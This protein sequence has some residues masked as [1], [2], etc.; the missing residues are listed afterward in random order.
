VL[1]STTHGA[2]TTGLAAMLA[3]IEAF[4]AKN[5]IEGNWLRGEDLKSRLGKIIEKHHLTSFLKI[6]GYPCLFTLAC[7]NPRGEIDDFYRTLM[8]QEMITRGVLFQG[9]FYPTWSH[10]QLEIDHISIA[11]DESCKIYRQAIVAGSTDRLLIGRP[12]KPVFRK[13]I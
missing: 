2:E 5:M 12:A 6:L 9:L 4:K 7:H 13:K 10:Q 11:F 1:I 8:M 3:T